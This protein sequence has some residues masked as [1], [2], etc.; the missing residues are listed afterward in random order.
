MNKLL[1]KFRQTNSAKDALK[2]LAYL[3]K[4]PFAVC[5]IAATPDSVLIANLREMRSR[6]IHNLASRRVEQ[7]KALSVE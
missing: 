4:H 7:A 3:D 2:L 6:A 1:A 5:L